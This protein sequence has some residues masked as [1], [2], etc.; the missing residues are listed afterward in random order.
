MYR[1]YSTSIKFI[2]PILISSVI[3]SIAERWPGSRYKAGNFPAMSTSPLIPQTWQSSGLH[4][5]L[6][7]LEDHQPQA[8]SS[9]SKKTA[10]CRWLS[11][12]RNTT[13]HLFVTLRY[14]WSGW[15]YDRCCLSVLWGSY[16]YLQQN[17]TAGFVLKKSWPQHQK[18][19]KISWKL[20]Q[21]QLINNFLELAL[22]IFW[23]AVFERIQISDQGRGPSWM[24]VYTFSMA[25]KVS[26]KYCIRELPVLMR[27]IR[28]SSKT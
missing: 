24:H 1:Y 4:L 19:D 25:N 20:K 28:L 11:V 22:I 2:S 27:L 5:H 21:Y 13:Y 12:S 16:H 18:P 17:R 14:P 6:Q 23:L 10:S 8:L 3:K 26:I 7:K 15:M 9:H